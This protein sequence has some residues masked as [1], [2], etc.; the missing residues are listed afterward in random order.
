MNWATP[1]LTRMEAMAESA[2]VMIR[3]LLRQPQ[4]L[5][6]SFLIGLVLASVVWSAIVLAHARSK[7]SAAERRIEEQEASR[8]QALSAMEERVKALSEKFQEVRQ[9][10]PA[11]GIPTL[12]RQGFNL[13]KR[14]Q[15]LRMHR[16]GDTPEQIAASLDITRQ[17]VDLL[18][19]V[20]R[21]VVSSF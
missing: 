1:A 6:F 12:P 18:L 10:P 2:V 5:G 16:R 8:A 9:Q 14:S 15:A 17:E 19:K 11:A 20:H 21:I 7:I 3:E 13:S 4:L